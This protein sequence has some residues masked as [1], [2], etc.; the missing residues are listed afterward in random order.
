MNYLCVPALIVFTLTGDRKSRFAA[1]AIPPLILLA[2]YQKICFGSFLTPSSFTFNFAAAAVDPQPSASIERPLTQYIFPLLFHGRFSPDVPI[3]P[4]WSAATF[5]GHTSVN[6]MT[7][8]EAIVFTRHPPGSNAAEWASFNLG[9]PL[10]GA[11][12]ARSLI[13]IALLMLTAFVAV[14]WK[15]RA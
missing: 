6:R 13:P 12:D 10:F 14:A 8:D 4:P 3:T 7:F 9:E 5:T 15:S 11:G 2:I 1:G